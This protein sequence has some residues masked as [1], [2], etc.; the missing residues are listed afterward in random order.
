MIEGLDKMLNF[1]TLSYQ[2]PEPTGALNSKAPGG[3]LHVFLY[4]PTANLVLASFG[5]T[6]QAH[7]FKVNHPILP[8]FIYNPVRQKSL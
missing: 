7:L 8:W 5:S 3:A 2:N 6:S 1:T 4:R